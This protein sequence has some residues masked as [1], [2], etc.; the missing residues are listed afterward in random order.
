[1]Q[2]YNTINADWIGVFPS[3][4]PEG[5]Y[6]VGL[7]IDSENSIDELNENNNN[8]IISYTRINVESPLPIIN[9]TNLIPIIIGIL[10]LVGI[11][12]VLGL[13]VRSTLKKIPDLNYRE[14]YYDPFEERKTYIYQNKYQS[15][16]QQW[17]PKFCTICGNKIGTGALFCQNCGKNLSNIY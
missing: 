8:E 11:I 4:V 6:Y 2:P 17:F 12:S 15:P 5:Y 16:N 14:F 9:P 13:V 1:M 3:N 10:A 7:I